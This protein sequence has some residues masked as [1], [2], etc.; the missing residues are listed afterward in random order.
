M[1]ICHDCKVF[2]Q[3]KAW[4]NKKASEPKCPYDDEYDENGVLVEGN[5]GSK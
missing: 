1:S 4:L 2:E 5:N 3:C